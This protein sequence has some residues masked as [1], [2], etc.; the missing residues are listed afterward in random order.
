MM[1][2]ADQRPLGA[3][4]REKS[5]PDLTIAGFAAETWERADGKSACQLPASGEILEIW[6]LLMPSGSLP[7]AVHGCI[8]SAWCTSP[9]MHG[10]ACV[11]T[12]APGTLVSGRASA[13]SQ[14]RSTNRN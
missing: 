6:R 13:R 10:V 12:I 14:P 3:A 2:V 8:P 5:Q 11:N 7:I 9:R 1:Q 4:L